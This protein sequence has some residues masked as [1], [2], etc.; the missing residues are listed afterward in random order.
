MHGDDDVDDG[1]AN[2]G[3]WEISNFDFI[4]FLSEKL[5]KYTFTLTV[6]QP[7]AANR[8]PASR[9]RA[10]HITFARPAYYYVQ[11]QNAAVAELPKKKIYS[12]IFAYDVAL[13]VSYEF[14][15]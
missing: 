5:N 6:T 3:I 2:G 15:V 1:A 7:A 10:I 11:E 9:F 8:W 14:R 12:R 13:S 4:N